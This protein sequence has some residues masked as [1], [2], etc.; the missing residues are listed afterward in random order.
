MTISFQ[1]TSEECCEEPRIFG[2]PHS[3]SVHVNLHLE[4]LLDILTA[5]A[6]PRSLCYVGSVVSAKDFFLFDLH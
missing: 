5:R 2:A 6:P 1:R 4:G 3:Y